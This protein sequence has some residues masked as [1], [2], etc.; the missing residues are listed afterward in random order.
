MLAFTDERVRAVAASSGVWLWRW[1]ALPPEER[2]PRYNL[3]KPPMPGLGEIVDQDDFLAGIAPRPYLYTQGDPPPE[4]WATS[5]REELT[6]KA[7][8]RYAEL[9]VAD[10]FQW[11]EYDGGK[12]AFRRHA[13]E[14]SYDWL[15]RWLAPAA[16]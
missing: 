3:P 10:R 7:R 16:S 11:L 9:G 12:H 15:D 8:E 5:W 13:R 2:P 14:R 6:R 1:C 4:P